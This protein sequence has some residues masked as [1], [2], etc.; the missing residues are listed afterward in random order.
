MLGASPP[1]REVEQ[2]PRVRQ[3]QLLIHVDRVED[4]STASA[5]SSHSGQS[6]LPSSGS[7]DDRPCP[8]TWT[9]TWMMHVEDVQGQP[10]RHPS[11]VSLAGC[12]G[13]QLGPRCDH[14]DQDG[15]HGRRSWKDALLWRAHSRKEH[16]AGSNSTAP[17]RQRS[18]TPAGRR[19]HKGGHR[20]HRSNGSNLKA[21][22]PLSLLTGLGGTGTGIVAPPLPVMQL[23][24]GS[25][26]GH[27]GPSSSLFSK[28]SAPL[29]TALPSRRTPTP[30]KTRTSATPTRQSARQAAAGHKA[31]MAQ[32]ASVL[33]V[34]QLGLLGPKEAMTAK[35]AEAL[36]KRFDEP[37]FDEDIAIIAKLTR[38]N[39]EAL[40]I[41][42]AMAGPDAVA[43]NLV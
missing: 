20:E 17:T 9:G 28:P 8:T 5:R 21:T 39:P 36:I 18:R 32:R 26:D 4:W 14:D 27:A 42:G 37:L 12:G 23:Q 1:S 19:Q 22:P 16:K 33:M 25:G 34:K 30:S 3:H 38:L 11:V 43:D 10:R 13:L 6:G 15:A 24:L 31:P 29:I 40:R 2:P 7:D 41:A 35:A